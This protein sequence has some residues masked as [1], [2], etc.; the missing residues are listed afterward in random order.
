MYKAEEC[1]EQR[2]LTGWVLSSFKNWPTI[3]SDRYFTQNNRIK[4]C[5]ENILTYF[6]PVVRPALCWRNSEFLLGE[7][8]LAANILWHLRNTREKYCSEIFCDLYFFPVRRAQCW[9]KG[10]RGVIIMEMRRLPIN[11]W[12]VVSFWSI[13]LLS[14]TRSEDNSIGEGTFM[15]SKYCW[16]QS[17]QGI[18]LFRSRLI[19]D[20]VCWWRWR[21]RRRRGDPNTLAKGPSVTSSSRLGWDVGLVES[22]KGGWAGF[23]SWHLWSLC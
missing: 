15:T 8:C 22:Y 18:S 10:K 20:T 4:Q 12:T 6:P 23:C 17:W 1:P 11:H 7:W 9:Q 5:S 21:C 3:F 2:I 19:V 13:V 16:L 14:R